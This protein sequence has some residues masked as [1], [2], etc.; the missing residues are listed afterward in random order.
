MK[1]ANLE[2]EFLLNREKL[3]EN[4]DEI[5]KIINN[6]KIGTTSNNSKFELKIPHSESYPN[7][8]INNFMAILF[9]VF[10]ILSKY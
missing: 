5:S 6:L 9:M 3:V 4:I 10:R 1:P 7:V 8:I 2:V